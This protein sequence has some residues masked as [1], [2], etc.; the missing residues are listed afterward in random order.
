M[1]EGGGGGGR[2]QIELWVGIKLNSVC[3]NWTVGA[4]WCGDGMHP[5]YRILGWEQIG[6]LGRE[7]IGFGVRNTEIIGVDNTEIIPINIHTAT[8]TV[9]PII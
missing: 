7:Q 6:I 2:D 9:C 4:V 8:D 1:S 3:L 5:M